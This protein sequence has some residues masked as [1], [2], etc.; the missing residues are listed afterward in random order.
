MELSL[1][2]I[3]AA[4]RDE[5]PTAMLEEVSGVSPRL[6]AATVL[7]EESAGTAMLLFVDL[8]SDRVPAGLGRIA[9]LTSASRADRLAGC[10]LIVLPDGADLVHALDAV[11]GLF[12]RFNRWSDEILRAIAAREDLQRI[13]DLTVPLVG[14]PLYIADMSFRMLASHADVLD[15]V[16]AVWRYHHA[17][18][19]LP[20]NVM[21]TLIDTGELDELNASNPARIFDPPRAFPQPQV[22]RAIGEEDNR[23]GFIFVL[24]LNSRVGIRECAIADFLGDALALVLREDTGYLAMGRF[25]HAHFLEE[26][27]EGNLTDEKVIA[28]QIRALGWD[29]K[30]DFQVFVL[31]AADDDDAV[32]HQLLAYLTALGS[33]CFVHDACIVALFGEVGKRGDLHAK[34]GEVVSSFNRYGALSERFERFMDLR[35]CYRQAEFAL[36]CAERDQERARLRSYDESFLDHLSVRIGGLEP[37]CIPIARLKAYDDEHGTE[38][39]RTLYVWLRCKCNTIA[40][41]ELLYVH[42]NTINYRIERI[43]EIVD[44]DVD[45]PDAYLRLLIALHTMLARE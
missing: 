34:L 8:L 31:D 9:V 16:D 29:L 10:D 6:T 44:F 45:E 42:R 15:E 13:V 1:A 12:T 26:V 11:N 37:P 43:H 39:C 36:S 27:I 28:D 18:R 41:A 35:L 2:F 25:Y 32:R 20:Y 38:L 23:L 19:Y 14:N 7:S 24:G 30:G 22:C 33:R 17:Y 3:H 21:K 4:L 5:Y 40:T